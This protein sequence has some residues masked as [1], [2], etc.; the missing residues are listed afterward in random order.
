MQSQ[1]CPKSWDQKLFQ[2]E[3]AY[4]ESTN[5]ST[6]LSPLH[7][8]YGANLCASLDLAPVSNLKRAYGK[9]E[10]LISQIQNIHKMTIQNLQ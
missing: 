9:A 6:K 10:D 2:A 7:I 3:F 8:V 4:N 5:Q 1:T